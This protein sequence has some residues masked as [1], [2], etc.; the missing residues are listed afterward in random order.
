MQRVPPGN[1]ILRLK[2]SRG[3]PSPSHTAHRLEV[4]QL[5]AA[6]ALATF[7]ITHRRSPSLET[8]KVSIGREGGKKA[9]RRARGYHKCQAEHQNASTLMRAMMVH[10][11]RVKC[12][13]KFSCA[14]LSARQLFCGVGIVVAC[15]EQVFY[16]SGGAESN[17][18][19]RTPE[20]NRV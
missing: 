17:S 11:L 20:A 4:W 15:R 12:Q 6:R 16:S 1:L 5:L 13:K 18:H 19:N 7:A 8:H 14:T 9:W 3:V 10:V 2:V